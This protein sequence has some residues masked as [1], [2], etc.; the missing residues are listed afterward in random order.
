METNKILRMD[1][2]SDQ[3][4]V[5][6]PDLSKSVLTQKCGDVINTQQAE[7]SKWNETRDLLGFN[8][9]PVDSENPM[10]CQSV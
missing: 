9:E 8:T 7:R 10:T 2:T 3:M 1:L 6:P 5:V 4:I